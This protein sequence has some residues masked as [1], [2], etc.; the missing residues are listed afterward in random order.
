MRPLTAVYRL[1]FLFSLLA[2]ASVQGTTYYVSTQGSDSNPG[3]STQPFRTLTAAYSHARAGDTLLVMAGVYTDYTS[4]W[5][6]HLGSSGTASSP[7]VLRSQVRGGAIIDGLNASDRNQGIYLDGSYNI[8]D[9]FEIRNGTHG[10]IAIY[11][12]GNRILNCHIHHNGNQASTS[13]NGRDGIYDDQT[14]SGNCY[15]GNYIHHNGRNGSNLDHGLYV[16]GDN[17]QVINNVVLI[18]AACGLQIAGYTTVNNLKVY[19]NVFAFNGTDG[20]IVWMA[21]SGIDIKNNVFSQNGHYGIGSYSATGNGVLV[22]HNVTYGNGYGDFDFTGGSF[23]YSL[24]TTFYSDPRFVNETSSGFDPHLTAGSP[25]ILAGVNLSSV[26]T[27]DMAGAS[28]PS[29]GP[30]DIGVYI[31]GASGTTDTTPPTVTVTAPANGAT[32]SGTISLSATASDNTA[33]ATVQFQLDGANLGAALTSAPYTATWDTTVAANGGHTLTA[34][35]S[36]AAGNHSSASVSITINNTTS[37]SAPT[38]ALV[39]P[40]SGS[41]YRSPATIILTADVTA[42]GHTIT[43][44]QFYSGSTLLNTVAVAPYSFTWSGVAVGSY[45]LTAIAV[46]DAGSTVTSAPAT[47]TVT[48]KNPRRKH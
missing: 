45:S 16:C 29:S 31:Y 17:E 4:G 36:D 10:G 5:G 39:S 3:T 8:V 19:N 27:T 47:V 13:T 14:T 35:A 21:L 2:L 7:I 20:I 32:V 46:Y 26:F 48:V 11:G 41:N 6:L 30:W 23:S 34:V 38:V 33:V 15:I 43:G 1:S 24:G 42:N 25:A 22:D 28:R 37:S 18:N 44:V 40:T 12:N 9:G